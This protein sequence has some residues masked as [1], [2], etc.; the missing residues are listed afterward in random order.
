VEGGGAGIDRN[1]SFVIANDD[2]LEK[3]IQNVL[4]LR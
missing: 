1:P 4:V 2:C 3:L